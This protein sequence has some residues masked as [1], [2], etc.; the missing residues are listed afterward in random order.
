MIKPDEGNAPTNSVSQSSENDEKPWRFQPGNPGGPGRPK[1]S[2]SGRAKLL[3]I[4]DEVLAEDESGDALRSAL[5]AAI[6]GEERT[7][8]QASTLGAWARLVVPLL[9]KDLRLELDM[10]GFP[11]AE[12][13]AAWTQQVRAE[14]EAK[15][16]G[17][18]VETAED[19]TA[20]EKQ[21]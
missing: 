16:N 21:T 3:A 12:T 1:G 15:V 18:G 11:A 9:P 20:G 10:R 2:V 4:F 8:A 7:K 14:A 19:A 5:R 6:R 13:F 17:N